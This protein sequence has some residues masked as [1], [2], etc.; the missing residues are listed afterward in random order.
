[1]FI[2]YEAIAS[3]VVVYSFISSEVN[4]AVILSKHWGHYSVWHMLHAIMFTP[5]GDTIDSPITSA[6]SWFFNVNQGV[7]EFQEQGPKGHFMNNFMHAQDRHT[8]HSKITVIKLT[9]ILELKVILLRL[10]P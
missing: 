7:S 2:G 8:N 9:L 10:S 3:G 1:M 4:P 6:I 5:D